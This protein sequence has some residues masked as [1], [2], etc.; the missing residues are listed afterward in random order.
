[1]LKKTEVIK[2]VYPCGEGLKQFRKEAKYYLPFPYR[3]SLC[4]ALNK[5]PF[6]GTLREEFFVN[7]IDC[8]YLKTSPH[9]PTADFIAKEF[10]F[11]VGGASKSTRQ[12]A[13]YIV[14]DGLDTSRNKLPLFAF[15][16]LY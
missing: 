6:I 9:S 14:T 12:D 16:L 11:E 13:D 2:R 4:T 8:C 5:T 1:M 15:G 10:V 7:H 3:Y